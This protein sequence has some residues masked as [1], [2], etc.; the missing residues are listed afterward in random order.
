MIL[1][2]ELLIRLQLY[3]ALHKDVGHAQ[4]GVS[5]AYCLRRAAGHDG[6]MK[7]HFYG[8]LD[9]ITVF[10]VQRTQGHSIAVHAHS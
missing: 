7:A 3:G 1:R 8:Q 6:T 4:I 10:D 2:E 9:G 5:L